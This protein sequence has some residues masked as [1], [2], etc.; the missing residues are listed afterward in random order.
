[1]FESYFG[2][3][4]SPF[5]LNPDPS[6][7]FASKGHRR[8]Y[9][10]LQHGVFE[11]EGF[12]VVTG[13]IGA[14]K[15]TLVRALLQELDSQ[16]VV[17][18]QLVST[19]LDSDNLLQSVAIAFGLPARTPGKTELLRDIEAFLA[20]LVTQG[21]RAL[22]IVDEAQNLMPGALEELR[23]LSNLQL[24]QRSLLQTFLIGQPELRE[25]LRADPMEQLRQR[26]SASYH[27]GPLEA[28]ETRAYVEHRLAH[29]GWTG[30][31][32]IAEQAFGRIH[33]ATG[34]IPR[35]INA[36]CKRLLLGAYLSKEHQIGPDQVAGGVAELRSEL[37]P[38]SLANEA[39]EV[40]KAP[41]GGTAP[42]AAPR[43]AAGT[44][45]ATTAAAAVKTAP[46]MA[47]KTAPATASK[48]AP[49]AAPRPAS[50]AASRPVPGTASRPVPG[51]A[52]RPMPGAAS[53]SAP[54]IAPRSAPGI[55]PRPTPGLAPR[56]A[57]PVT[58][59][60]S[61][62]GTAKSPVNGSANGAVNGSANGSVLGSA[63][64]SA[65]GSVAATP[66]G[67][68]A[69]FMRPFMMSAVTARL[70][71]LEVNTGNMLKM[72]RALAQTEEPKPA[73][74]RNAAPNK[75]PG[76]GAAGRMPPTRR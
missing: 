64:G 10:Y 68:Q 8:A 47:G 2:L 6:F 23:I 1:M 11:G 9:A 75:A 63:N 61:A 33:R 56:S 71:R 55:V 43:T 39:T 72:V 69:D 48:T 38:D 60:R 20:D 14:G 40:G 4:A 41:A 62:P 54:G 29:A 58:A 30:D 7:L 37:G 18:A 21:K 28:A 44:A 57:A 53:R 73:P 65:N 35:R 16:K 27:L 34:G 67:D 59:P 74:K 26:I 52:S 17:A 66:G 76:P 42:G 46:G 49:G 25:M 5:Q 24:E 50:G 32:A 70:D 51:T 12:I 31:P 13:E 15:T 19:R 22:L 45:P 3:K 36:L